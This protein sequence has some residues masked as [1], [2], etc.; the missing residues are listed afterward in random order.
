MERQKGETKVH[1]SRKLGIV[2]KPVHGS[3]RKIGSQMDQTFL[4]DRKNETRLILPGRYR[5]QGV[6]AFLE[7]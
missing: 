7:C 5:R 4:G 1:Q 6:A 3:L 2:V